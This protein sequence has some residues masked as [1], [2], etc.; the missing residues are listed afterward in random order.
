[1]KRKLAKAFGL[2]QHFHRWSC[3]ESNPT[4]YQGFC[5]LS[6]RFVTSRSGSVPLVT[7]GFRSR[8]LTASKPDRLRRCR[9]LDTDEAYT[10]ADL[11][12]RGNWLV[13][14]RGS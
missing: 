7:C 4:L 14:L 6:C 1:M 12:S 11:E 9:Q 13:S 10:R 3:R 5:L 8:V 2:D